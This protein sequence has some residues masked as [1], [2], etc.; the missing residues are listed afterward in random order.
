MRNVRQKLF[1][2]ANVLSRLFQ[3]AHKHLT[4]PMAP[5]RRR[6]AQRSDSY[7]VCLDCGQRFAYDAN[8]QKI[9]AALPNRPAESQRFA[10]T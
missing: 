8:Q 1:M 3:C 4:R 6:G 5:V 7:L 10:D 2:V 9:G